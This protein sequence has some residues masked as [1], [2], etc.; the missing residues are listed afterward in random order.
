MKKSL[1]TAFVI[2]LSL[3]L[4]GC[5]YRLA[6]TVNPLLDGYSSIAIPYF[7]NKTFEAE[8]VSIFTHAFVDEFVESRRLKVVPLDAADLVL[9]GTVKKLSEETVAYNYDDKALEYRIKV[10]LELSLEDKATGRVIWKRK[11]LSHDE[12]Y[13]TGDRVVVSETTKRKSLVLL[14]EDL[15][16]RA[17]DSILQGF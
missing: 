14:A 8:A 9:Y 16:E 4:S 15:A 6:N 7:K 2:L 1:T 3:L 5:G 17:H 12:E 13:L 11:N 10:S